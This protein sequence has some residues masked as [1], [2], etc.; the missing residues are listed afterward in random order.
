TLGYVVTEG[1]SLVYNGKTLYESNSPSSAAFTF[2]SDEGSVIDCA[3]G[4]TVK[5]YVPAD[6]LKYKLIG[7]K[8]NG[9]TAQYTV[10]ENNVMTFT[11]ADGKTYVDFVY[12]KP[13]ADGEKPGDDKPSETTPDNGNL[14]WIIIGSV[15]AIAV[16]A[17][18]LSVIA[19][20]KKKSK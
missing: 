1:K 18:V 8:L 9:E 4:G 17:A 20:K 11:V 5:L 3:K 6:S 10:D 15:A 14:K 12:D 2:E 16:I 7:L 13:V 19:H